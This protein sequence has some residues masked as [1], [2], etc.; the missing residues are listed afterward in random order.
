[1]LREKAEIILGK[2]RRSFLLFTFL[3]NVNETDVKNYLL[4]KEPYTTLALLDFDHLWRVLAEGCF[5]AIHLN[6]DLS[7]C[8]S[9]EKSAITIG[10]TIRKGLC[11][12]K[13]VKKA[14]G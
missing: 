4:A 12:N 8:Y 11:G 9:A 6:P 14:Q 2:H 3:R 1:M 5:V 10:M 7:P 13:S